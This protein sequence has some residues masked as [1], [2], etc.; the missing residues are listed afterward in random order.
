ME[1]KATMM[2]Y[3]TPVRIGIA[4]CTMVSKDTENL[5]IVGGYFSR[6]IMK[7]VW[8]FLRKLKIVQGYES[9]ILEYI[10]GI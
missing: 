7:N 6:A 8:S 5:Y 10:L 2:Y 9:A 1:V 4:G 3:L